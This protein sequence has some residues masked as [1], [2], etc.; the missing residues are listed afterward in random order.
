MNGWAFGSNMLATGNGGGHWSKL[1]TFCCSY[2]VFTDVWFTDP[3]NGWTIAL[4]NYLGNEYYDFFH[5]GDGGMTWEQQYLYDRTGSTKKSLF[6]TDHSH[7]WAAGDGIVYKTANGGGAFGIPETGD[8]IFG[9]T[10]YPNPAPDRLMVHFRLVVPAPVLVTISDHSGK[11]M[12]KRMMECR[13]EGEQSLG[14]DVRHYAPGV[15]LVSLQAG[16]AI[17]TGRFTVLR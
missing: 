7:G 11:I 17:R 3:L 10:L 1:P 16:G 2:D 12:E 14:I 4:Y 8:G 5:T 9:M 15:Y 13:W 6:F